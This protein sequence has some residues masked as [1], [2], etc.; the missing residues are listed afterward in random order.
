VAFFEEEAIVIVGAA[1]MKGSSGHTQKAELT[2]Q[3]TCQKSSR[4]HERSGRRQ[5]YVSI[6]AG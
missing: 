3:C 6:A 2:E 5:V 1:V 4:G